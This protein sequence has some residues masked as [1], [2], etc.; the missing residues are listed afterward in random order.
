MDAIAA[1]LASVQQLSD[2]QVRAIISEQPP[3]GEQT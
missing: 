2:E 1:V 3:R